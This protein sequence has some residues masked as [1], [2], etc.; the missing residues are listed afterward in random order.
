M[1]ST[2]VVYEDGEVVTDLLFQDPFYATGYPVTE[3]YWTRALVGG[4]E[5]DVLVQAFERRVLTYTPSNPEGW[6]VESGN[7]GR[8]YYEWF[9]GE[10]DGVTETPTPTAT[11][12]EDPD[13]EPA[14]DPAYPDFCIAPPPPLLTC[15]DASLNGAH[16]F[17]V[18]DPDPHGFDAD[19]DGIGC[20][21]EASVDDDD[22][23]SDVPVVGPGFTEDP[24]WDGPV[25]VI[26]TNVADALVCVYAAGGVGQGGKPDLADI[27]EEDCEL[28]LGT[29]KG[30]G[31][32][33]QGEPDTFFA[34]LG[35]NRTAAIAFDDDSQ[36]LDVL[37][38]VDDLLAGEDYS[39]AI[40]G[41]GC[42]L[43]LDGDCTDDGEVGGTNAVC[44][45]DAGATLP[46]PY[47]GDVLVDLG[48]A[49]ADANGDLA[50]AFTGVLDAFQTQQ[51]GDFEDN[52]LVVM[53]DTGAIVACGIIES[54]SVALETPE[55]AA[56]R[57][58][59]VV[60]GVADGSGDI[61]FGL[62]AG[63]YYA[64]INAAGYQLAVEEFT[65]DVDETE[66]NEVNLISD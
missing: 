45:P 10:D 7:V 11:P 44:S 19:G 56:I 32:A 65:L 31:N 9:H 21:Q 8:H 26:D 33:G 25:K 39:A 5:T 27:T 48:V 1:T 6:Q 64:V 13:A 16:D 36:D 52:V 24:D 50:L 30:G 66:L 23:G 15:D 60:V 4:T 18:L 62:P 20:E 59:A 12:T 51:L 53:D 57:L 22:G 47:S 41:F 43:N 3:A 58:G 34:N 61:A 49:T 63:D 28:L 42:D 38:E 55:E 2:G 40:A 37:V 29:G 14:C 54:G 17:T 46:N 35:E